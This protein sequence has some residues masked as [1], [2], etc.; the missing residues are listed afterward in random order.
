MK[1]RTC[2]LKPALSRLSQ[3]PDLL[4]VS[5]MSI[6]YVVGV[7]GD[8]FAGKS[9]I[10]SFL[11][12]R[13]HFRLYRLSQFVFEEARRRGL[14]VGNKMNLR[15]VG[16]ELRS[17]YGNDAI[18]RMA[19]ERIRADHLDADRRETPAAIVIEG[20]K[21]PEELE[22]WQRLSMFR[23]IL[24][25]A[26]TSARMKR[27]SDAGFMA[28]ERSDIRDPFPDSHEARLAWFRRHVDD[29]YTAS[30]VVLRAQSDPRT[31]RVTNSDEGI[32][33]VYDQLRQ[34]VLPTLDRSWRARDI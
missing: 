10:V 14:D 34:R 31:L 15:A 3:D 9:T 6:R 25:D 17:Q 21:V 5:P 18:A 4:W 1:S 20:F 23:T 13:R 32:P 8:R 26:E 16:D 11:V 7:V 19:F 27:M 22:A 29:P 12:S 24:V 30:G 33:N 28:D 2:P